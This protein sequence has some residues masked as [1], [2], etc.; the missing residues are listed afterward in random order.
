MRDH[1]RRLMKRQRESL[2]HRIMKLDR[3]QIR[4]HL[5]EQCQVSLLVHRTEC[6]QGQKQLPWLRVTRDQQRSHQPQLE[7]LQKDFQLQMLLQ[8][9]LFT[10]QQSQLQQQLVSRA[11]DQPQYLLFRQLL[12]QSQM[13]NQQQTQACLASSRI[14][15][16]QLLLSWLLPFTRP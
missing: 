8:R 13:Q 3:M 6:H 4:Q 16:Q 9:H 15:L 11:F 2:L 12:H 10:N 1:L 5:S 7:E 14:R